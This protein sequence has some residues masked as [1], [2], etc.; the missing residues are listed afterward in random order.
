MFRRKKKHVTTLDLTRLPRHIAIV[1]DGNGRWASKRGL[2]RSAGHLAGSENFRRIATYC[3]DIGLPYLTVFA[4]STE[5]W[6]RSQDEVAGIIKLLEKY[7]LESLE[8][9]ERDGYRLHF[10]G[11]LTGIPPALRP[12][13]D[14]ADELSERIQ[15][16]TVNV[17]FNYGGRDEILRAA[18]TLA[19]RCVSG[20][21][22]PEDI[23]EAC[24]D[25]ALDTAHLPP[26]DL[27]I[28][29][30]GECRISNFLLWQAA[31]AELYFTDVLWPD[32]S[33]RHLDEAIL[34]YQSRVRRF[35]GV[36]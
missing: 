5:N 32:F 31:Y 13:V 4:F 16:L 25:A 7:L 11:D 35:G 33:P 1:M 21:L 36:V 34:S 8:K 2:P 9:M 18:R 30:S 29:P 19:G 22:A 3:K 28:R 6:K 24:F 12:L 23:D 15:G 27:L 20:E 14:R 17:A 26:L 10:L